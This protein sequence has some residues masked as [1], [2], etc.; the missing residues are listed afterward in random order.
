MTTA[1]NIVAYGVVIGSGLFI[2]YCF[3][4]AAI[5]SIRESNKE[6]IWALLAFV[7]II[8]VVVWSLFRVLGGL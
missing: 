5:E 8:V 6:A 3:G 2:I 4:Q 7:L 1:L